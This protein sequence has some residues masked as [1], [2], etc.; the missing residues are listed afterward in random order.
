[1]DARKDIYIQQVLDQAFFINN[2]SL[3]GY[4]Q[5]HLMAGKII[6]TK[7]LPIENANDFLAVANAVSIAST[8]SLSSDFE[9]VMTYEANDTDDQGSCA[10]DKNNYFT[11][12]DHFTVE[13]INSGPRDQAGAQ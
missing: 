5:K 3:R 7:D 12:K 10:A 4:M 9:F 8:S 11:K 1:M 13:L 2:N 6:S